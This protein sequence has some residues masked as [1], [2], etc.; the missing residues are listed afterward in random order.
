M[1]HKTELARLRLN[2]FNSKMEMKSV[3][4]LKTETLF[5]DIP[6]VLSSFSASVYQSLSHNHVGGNRAEV[7]RAVMVGGHSGEDERKSRW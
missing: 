7:A 2:Q 5:S 3:G 4:K 6:A 1:R